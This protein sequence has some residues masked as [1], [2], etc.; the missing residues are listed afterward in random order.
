MQNPA[1]LRVR[2]YL[3]RG[4]EALAKDFMLEFALGPLALSIEGLNLILR[5]TIG[6][7]S[8]NFTHLANYA[9]LHFDES[10]VRSYVNARN[11]FGHWRA[12]APT[13][14][15]MQAVADARDVVHA[16]LIRYASETLDEREA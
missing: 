12:N 1:I 13:D 4:E 7:T 2:D 9:G 8:E 5:R 16:T 6:T 11:Q 14:C 3:S 10:R 15:M